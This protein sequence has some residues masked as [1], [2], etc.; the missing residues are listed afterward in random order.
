MQSSLEIDQLWQRTMA[1][2]GDLKKTNIDQLVM[3]SKILK[4]CPVC[5]IF[6]TVS[7]A[8]PLIFP[9]FTFGLSKEQKK[10]IKIARI[11]NAHLQKSEKTG[12]KVFPSGNERTMLFTR[13]TKNWE[14]NPKRS[15]SGLHSF[16]KLPDPAVA[17]MWL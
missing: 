1:T 14:R 5:A 11:W 15:S 16:E 4:S 2:S 9:S 7:P 6:Q 10:T 12:S 13:R 3:F 17:A 8:N